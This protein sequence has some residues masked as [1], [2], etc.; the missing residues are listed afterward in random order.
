MQE[1]ERMD[2]ATAITVAEVDGL[3]RELVNAIARMRQQL[4][5]EAQYRVLDHLNATLADEAGDEFDKQHP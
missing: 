1:R 5:P 2:F 4:T 3:E